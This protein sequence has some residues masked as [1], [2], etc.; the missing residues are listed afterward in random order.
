MQV[1]CGTT[2]VF[3]SIYPFT[4]SSGPILPTVGYIPYD[5]TTSPSFEITFVFE[6]IAVLISGIMYTS[7][8]ALA[9]GGYFVT[10]QILLFPLWSLLYPVSKVL[11]VLCIL[12]K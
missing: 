4:L 12:A 3:W 8:L 5:T 11:N 7:A 2:V 9:A 6:F 10:N 1:S